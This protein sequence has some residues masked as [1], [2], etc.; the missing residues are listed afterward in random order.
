ML[1]TN[2]F[3][4]Y[5]LISIV[6]IMLA[7]CSSQKDPAQKMINDIEAAV[8]A[9]AA[10]AAKY[11]PDQMV[12]VQNEFGE[13]KASFDKKDYRAVVSGA[14]PVMSAAQSLASATAAKKDQVTK[15]LN[16]EWTAFASALPGAIWMR[17]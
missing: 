17:R 2:P 7:A 6:G 9:A 11:V 5:A 10:D 4:Q 15:G 8:N 12:D 3:R 1:S 14:P 13:L 16:D